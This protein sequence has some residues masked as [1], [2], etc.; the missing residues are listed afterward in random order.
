MLTVLLVVST[1]RE[2]PKTVEYA[3]KR[4]KELNAR[5]VTLCVIDTK[6]PQAI[7]EKLADSGFVGD[8]PGEGFFKDVMEEY[9][10]R[11]ERKLQEICQAA[12][13]LSIPTKGI[14][15]EGDFIKEC[16]NAIEEEK[17]YVV[18][19]GKKKISKLSQFIFGSPIKQIESNARCPVEVVEEDKI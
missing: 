14:L 16:L 4:V 15:R 19:I 18:I 8:K 1:T 17:A 7:Q 13:K 6:L 10:Q 11:G 12:E 2:S 3:L 9:R 5:L